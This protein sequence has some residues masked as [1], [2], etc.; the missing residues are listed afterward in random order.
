MAGGGDA[1]ALKLSDVFTLV[2]ISLLL[3]TFIMQVWVDP[4]SLRMDESYTKISSLSDGDV[5]SA[6]VSVVNQSEVSFLVYLDEEVVYESEVIILEGDDESF[7]YEVEESGDYLV[8]VVSKDSDGDVLVDF[9]RKMM[10][11]KALYLVGALML[12]FGLYKRKEEMEAEANVLDADL[13][14]E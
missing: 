7:E 3:G 4:V 1:P 2:G 11:D 6:E 14:L 9:D 5:I 8:E 10:L 12:G 13:D